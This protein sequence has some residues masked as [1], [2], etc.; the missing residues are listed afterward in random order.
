LQS[1]YTT[2]SSSSPQRTTAR[3]PA[4]NKNTDP[5]TAANRNIDPQ[6]ARNANAHPDANHH[7]HATVNDAPDVESSA[8]A[9]EGYE[10]PLQQRNATTTFEQIGAAVNPRHQSH[11]CCI[12]NVDD[13]TTAPGTA[14]PE[15]EEKECCCRKGRG[16]K[17]RKGAREF[18]ALI[19]PYGLGY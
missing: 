11:H 17:K 18:G 5:Q 7:H 13:I 15:G 19:K 2:I 10:P 12:W 6:P 9:N 8:T 14:M 16:K 3:K 1:H 4:A